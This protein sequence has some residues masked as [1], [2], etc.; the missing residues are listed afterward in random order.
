MKRLILT[1]L[2]GIVI[3]MLKAQAPK[4]YI[5]I[6][7]HN[8]PTDNL[9]NNLNYQIAKTKMQQMASIVN[10]KNVKWNVQTSDGF[11]FGAR[12]DQNQNGTNIFSF[13]ANAPYSDNIE[14]DPRN[15]NLYGRNIADQWYLLDSLGA[16]P[17]HHLGGFIYYTSNPNA[18]AIDW[19][20]YRNPVVGTV[21]GNSWQCSLLTGAGSYPPHTNDLNDF[22]CFKPN[23][24]SDFYNHNENQ[25]L[26]CI[27]VGCAPV[28]DSLDNE[29]SI[30]DLIQ[31]QVDSIQNGLW[32]QD[33]FYVTRIMTNQREYG[34]M[35]FTKISK[36]IDSLNLISSDYLQWATISESFD[37]FNAWRQDSGNDYSQWLCGETYNQIVNNEK[38]FFKIYPNPALETISFK[39][40][41]D[42][43][44][45]LVIFSNEGK[46]IYSGYINNDESIDIS[47][48]SSGIYSIKVD[49][50][51][52][53]KLIKM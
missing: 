5:Q 19:E 46:Q 40:E 33:K 41:N 11:V 39:F 53:E 50:Q 23:S 49:N 17:T 37:A 45:E 44:H 8:E 51:N 35:F 24:P 13:L 43:L 10:Q 32:P 1:F 28:L 14:I 48:F 25:N 6:V 18:T 9:Q 21:H 26:W 42:N 38:T 31:G 52:F 29:Q 16:N 7:S 47:E 2:F 12:T 27:G 22:G 4:L 36:V 30:I 3:T 34:P 15:K 20:Q